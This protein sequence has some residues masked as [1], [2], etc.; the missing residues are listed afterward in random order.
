MAKCSFCGLELPKGTG[1]MY[2][3]KDG[4]ILFFCSRRCEKNLLKLKRVPR[5]TQWTDEYARLHKKD[6]KGQHYKDKLETKS[7]VN[8]EKVQD[9]EGND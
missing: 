5:E 6:K 3:K 8:Q 1:K 2:V 7:S 9:N 4:K